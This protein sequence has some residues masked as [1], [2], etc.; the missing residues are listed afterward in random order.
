MRPS[1]GDE[2]WNHT[3]QVQDQD[4]KK[5]AVH[6]KNSWIA[7]ILDLRVSGTKEW[8]LVAWLYWPADLKAAHGQGEPPKNGRKGY[9]GDYELVP[10]NHLDIMDVRTFDRVFGEGDINVCFE[11][12]GELLREYL[13]E[14]DV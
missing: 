7:S 10:S 4:L 2:K 6:P 14:T 13:L 11:K 3:I 12:E 5:L 1:R 8:A 9:H